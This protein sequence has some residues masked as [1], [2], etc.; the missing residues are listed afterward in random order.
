[1]LACGWARPICSTIPAGA[2]A[3]ACDAALAL[4]LAPEMTNPALGRAS[5]EHSCA[6]S[7][8][9]GQRPARGPAAG[10]VDGRNGPVQAGHLGPAAAPGLEKAAIRLSLRVGRRVPEGQLILIIALLIHI[11]VACI[12]I[13]LVQLSN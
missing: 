2:C 12:R 4:V 6:A 1:M 9:K 3:N 13:T 11:F 10:P 8:Q 7:L 5:S